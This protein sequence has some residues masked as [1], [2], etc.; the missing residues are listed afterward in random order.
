M[1][2]ESS[3]KALH[4]LCVKGLINLSVFST[5][6]LIN[7]Y[8]KFGQIGYACYVFD[9]MYDRN[10]SSWNN[11]ISGFVRV[12]LYHEA[13]GFLREM[14]DFGVNP[15]VFFVASLFAACN[16]SGCMLREGT[17][18]H[19]LVVK[20]GLLCDVFVGTSLLHF[21]AA[22]GFVSN[23]RKLFEEMPN[24]N[25][26]SW[27]SLMVGYSD[28]GDPGEVV[29]MY[30]QMRHEG[31]SCNGN[32]Y[33]IVISSC[34]LLENKFLGY[35]VL[36]CVIKSGLES[37][38]SVGNS[39]VSMFG[40]FSSMEEASYVFCRMNERD[41]IS[42]NSMLAANAHNGLC[43][44]S[45]RCFHQMRLI[46][47]EINS[48]T[49]STIIS[50]C[51]S[52]DYLKWGRGIHGLVVKVGLDLNVFLCNTLLSMYSDAGRSEDAELVFQTMP[53]K[54]LISW[55][56][57]LSC[58][59]QDGRCLGALNLLFEL[60]RTIKPINF[61]TF[62]SAV[63]ACSNSKDLIHGKTVHALVIV[64]GLYN[65][66]IV[67]NALVTMYAKLGRMVEANQVLE[68]MPKQEEVTWNAFIGGY[69]E[70]N[71]PNESIKA[72][73]MMRKE[74]IRAS[75]ITI[76]NLLGAFWTPN[77]LPKHG[78]PI[79]AHIIF[80]GFE[81]DIHV[82]NSLIMMYAKCGDLNS[83][84]YI[85]DGV[86]N[87]TSITC[88]AIISANTYNGFDEKA[89]KLL[90]MMRRARIDLDHVTLSECL[91]AA[92]KLA[93]LEEGQ[94]VHGLAVK[95]GYAADNI[96]INSVMD[97]YGKCGEMDD[98]LR[99]LPEPSDRPRLS[100][101]ILISAFARH[102]SIKKAME[103]FHEMLR[104][105]QRPDHVTFVSLLSACSHGGLVDEGLA[106]YASMAKEFG[107]PQAIEHCVCI[108]DLLGRSGRLSEAE[109]FIKE[110]PVPPN[111][112]VWRSL[113]AACKI[114]GNLELARKAA[115]H[116]FKLDPSDDSAYVLYSNV[117]ATTGRWDDLEDVR[118]EMGFKKVKKEPACSWVN[119]K[120]KVASFGMGDR[121]HPQTTQIYAKFEELRKMV[122]EAG[123]IPD[124]SYALQDTDEEQK[125]HNLWN[126]SE[127]LAL[128]YGLIN[129]SDGST[130]KIF[131]NLR[132]CGDCHSVYKFV[133]AIMGRRIILRDPY[134]FHHFTGGNCS[135]SDYW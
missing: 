38:V 127:R 2:K 15:S 51:S 48:V 119:M 46:H 97:M 85:F 63:V 7:V 34:G 80:T 82:Q 8:S 9:K 10:K 122:K 78:M 109:S 87:K 121:S 29:D 118:R 28:K 81:S 128:A 84:N 23:A 111:D 74:G 3:V 95:L 113:L 11:M 27:T 39:L 50:A 40:S 71:E 83:S 100:W 123:Y 108:A 16:R 12:E 49:I 65:N 1:T 52:A 120:N 129:T 94:Q 135:C 101:N 54:D 59:A 42:W 6:T 56:S 14:M 76:S 98:V 114:H 133:S 105:G 125:E 45:L 126:H 104:Q 99:I 17:Q 32:T 115:E 106:Y 112:F 20:L 19:G 4:A 47:N 70:N 68:T 130:V 93:I 90:V 89:L 124:T 96:F 75:Y 61:V 21:Y 86:A 30:R 69:A 66:L 44:E 22:Y 37:N 110:M 102:G 73:K 35:Q 91:V 13:F 41:S 62:T 77:D 131:K 117:C 132:V 55:N 53:E 5:N 24:R 116:L 26:V 107:F 43:E 18:V 31:V 36:G 58:Y 72:F 88:N 134:R 64:Y 57:M 60:F 103:T 33:T 79:H 67:G 25:V 92:A